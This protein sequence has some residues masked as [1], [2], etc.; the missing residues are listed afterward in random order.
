MNPQITQIFAEAIS[1]H[2][3]VWWNAPL[4]ARFGGICQIDLNPRK[5][6]R[7]GALHRTTALNARALPSQITHATS[8]HGA[9]IICANLPNL[10]INLAK[11]NRHFRSITKLSPREYR[12]RFRE[13]A[14]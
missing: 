10:R 9:K 2:G 3:H 5:R 1:E 13:N 6:A 11:F 14:G 12:R 7:S 4:R 8:A